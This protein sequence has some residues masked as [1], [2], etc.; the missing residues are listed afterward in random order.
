MEAYRALCDEAE[1]QGLRVELGSTGRREETRL[2]RLAI[3]TTDG[4]EVA[5][6]RLTSKRSIEQASRYLLRF[7]EHRREAARKV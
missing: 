3:E 6:L 4:I 5:A 2:S 1:A 7:L